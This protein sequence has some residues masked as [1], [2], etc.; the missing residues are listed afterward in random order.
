MSTPG[1]APV[2]PF[3]VGC[4]RSGTTMLRAMFDSH[5]EVVGPA[6]V[7]LRRSRP[8]GAPRRVRAGWRARRRDVP[9]RPAGQPVVPPE[10]GAARRRARPRCGTTR[11][12]TPPPHSLRLYAAYA[13][14]RDK[15]RCADKTP[16]H[17]LHLDLLA[18]SFPGSRFVHLVRDGRDVVP[19]LLENRHGPTRF[20]DAVEY[21][22]TRVLAGRRAGDAP[23][24]RAVPRDPLRGAG[25]GPG[26][27]LRELCAF[28]DLPYAPAMLEYPTRAGELVAGTFDARPHLG[29]S[30][31]PTSNVRD[32]RTAMPDHEVQLFEAIAGDALDTFGYERSGMAAVAAGAGRAGDAAGRRRAATSGVRRLRRGRDADRRAPASGRGR[33]RR[34]RA[35]GPAAR[36]TAGGSG[37][38]RS[39][40]EL[41]LQRRS[42]RPRPRSGVDRFRGLMITFTHGAA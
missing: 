27:Q 11:R 9:R 26:A 5:P 19:S 6:R 16:Q 31:A 3:L 37:S 41:R 28:L 36:R 20:P 33:S 25:R 12:P 23:R 13:A 21:W 1:A 18:R 8:C 35:R 15:T 17:V 38:R 29:I 39:G 40:T 2:F 32:W 10:L 14:E 7:V 24:A 34:C 42:T 22:R 30:Q 4:N